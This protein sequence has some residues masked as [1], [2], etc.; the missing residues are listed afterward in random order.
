MSHFP[1]TSRRL[2]DGLVL[3]RVPADNHDADVVDTMTPYYWSRRTASP[4]VSLHH[5]SNSKG[6]RPLRFSLSLVCQ[7]TDHCSYE[8]VRRQTSVEID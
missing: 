6:K 5:E 3:P 2:S 8:S 1:P 4:L 7:L